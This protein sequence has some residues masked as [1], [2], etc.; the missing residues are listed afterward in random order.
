MK[1]TSF[2]KPFLAIVLPYLLFEC[3]RNGLLKDPVF[4][5]PT[6][7][8]YIVSIVAFLSTII[9]IAVGIAGKRLRNIKISF[10]SLAFVSLALMFSL[11]GLS[12]PHFILPATHLPGI[13]AQLS[14]LLATL[15]LY[16]SSLPSD[17]KIVEVFSQ[18]QTYLLPTWIVILSTIE[19]TALFHPHLLGIIPITARP[20]NGLLTVFIIALNLVTIWRYYQT[21]RF[22]RFPLQIAIVYSAGWFI[23]AQLIIVMG[24]LW[25]LSWWIYHFLLLGS[26]IAML[27]GLVKQYGVKGNLIGSIKALYT[28]DPFERVTN[29]MSPSVKKL[30]L[31]TEQKDT[32]T[33]GH[34][35]RVTMYALKLAEAMRIKP[36][37]LRAIA[38]GA[39]VHDVGKIKLPDH[40]LNKPGNLSKQERALIEKHPIN[41]YEMCRDLGFMKDELVIIRSHHEKWDGTGYPDQL[42]G[43]DIPLLARITAVADVYDALT[44]ERSYRNAWSHEKAISF[45]QQEK[46]KHFDPVCVEAW[47]NLCEKKPEVYLYPADHITNGT[48]KEFSSIL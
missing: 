16:L 6:G 35:F 20:L 22:S 41:G 40:V 29:N 3:L 38:Q 12:T 17:N 8:F 13:A 47:V 33:A 21:Y 19:V 9:A 10:L 32:Y 48:V 2:Y 34:T 11:H 45:L 15:W 14:M 37:Q 25:K 43:E 28:N 24:E 42:S 23:G 27:V 44:S 1:T 39:L 36:E 30:V 31:A 7:H 46:G 18:K 5:M 4:M 26:V